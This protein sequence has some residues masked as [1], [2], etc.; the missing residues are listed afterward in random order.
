MEKLKGQ[1]NPDFHRFPNLQFLS[2]AIKFLHP[3][4]R[5]F[6]F[7]FG[8]L[9]F[10]RSQFA[11]EHCRIHWR[12]PCRLF[13]RT[14]QDTAEPLV[15]CVRAHLSN[16]LGLTIHHALFLLLLVIGHFQCNTTDIWRYQQ[17]RTEVLYRHIRPH[18]LPR[19]FHMYSITFTT[20]GWMSWST[21][22]HFTLTLMRRFKLGPKTKWALQNTTRGSSVNVQVWYNHRHCFTWVCHSNGVTNF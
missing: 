9:R 16:F 14:L 21:H 11:I 22:F 19:S 10:Q 12:P 3:P 1:D 20:Y 5:E 15:N 18:H 13:H 4:R 7:L 17:D 8:T 2:K 6:D